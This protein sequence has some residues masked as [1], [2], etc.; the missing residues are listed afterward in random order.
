MAKYIKI[1]TVGQIA[2]PR[3]KNKPEG[4]APAEHV[5]R[6]MRGTLD[7]IMLDRP[8]LIVLSEVADRPCDL[9]LPEILE[10]YEARGD[11]LLDRL[12]GYAKE[13][14]VFLLYNAV[15]RDERGDYRNASTLIDRAGTPIYRYD[16]TFPTVMEMEAYGVRPGEGAKVVDCELGRV[17]AITCFDMNFEELRQEYAALKPQLL[18]FSSDYHGGPNRSA[19][20]LATR[21]YLVAAIGSGGP[22]GIV[23]PLGVE[24]ASVSSYAQH[25]VHTVNLDYVV[26]HLDENR[27]AGFVAL[28]EAYGAKAR[29]EVP[30][31]LG[32]AIVT[33]ECEEKTAMDFVRE[34]NLELLDDYLDR[35]RAVRRAHL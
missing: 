18:L 22:G 20:A 30:S 4:V 11:G 21:S 6:Y 23:N 2:R 26:C 29:I 1:A 17:G 3:L 9:S 33:S 27:S 31:Y 14:A 25:T 32:W 5:F 13:H 7:R 19:Y 15:R 28:K 10:Y 24:V 34:F 16:K 12:C 8:D 35:A